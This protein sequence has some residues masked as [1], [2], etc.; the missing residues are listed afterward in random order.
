MEHQHLL[1]KAQRS[2][3]IHFTLKAHCGAKMGFALTFDPLFPKIVCCLNAII[4]NGGAKQEILTRTVLSTASVTT[5]NLL[6]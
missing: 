4:S 6:A 2:S 1:I 5:K 3:R